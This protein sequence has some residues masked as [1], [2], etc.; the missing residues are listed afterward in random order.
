MFTFAWLT[1]LPGLD[2][3]DE[4]GTIEEQL[5]AALAPELAAVDHVQHTRRVSTYSGISGTT[6]KT[7]FSQEEIQDL[8]S[9]I[10]IDI[11]PSL[12]RSSEE[13]AKFLL[14][15]DLKARPVV[16]KE[17]RTVNSKYN[18][19]YD[20]RLASVNVHKHSFGSTQFIQPSIVLRALFDVQSAQDVPPGPWRPDGVIY[21]INL[22]QMLR[23]VLIVLIDNAEITTEGYNAIEALDVNFASAIAGPEFQHNAFELQLSLLTQLAIIRA[24]AYQ[25]DPTF[26]I[27][28]TITDTFFIQDND[29]DL[30][31]KH[32][33]VLHMMTLSPEQQSQYTDAIGHR[34]DRIIT[35]LEGTDL[36]TGL[37]ALRAQYLWEDFVETVIQY[38]EQ[39]KQEV[40]G[41]IAAV[42]GIEQIIAGLSEEVERRT[43]ARLA[44]EKRK[45]FTKP[46]PRKS[47]GK[48]GIK[49]LKARE[50][51]LAASTAPPAPVAE[52]A[53]VAQMTAPAA[54]LPDPAPLPMDDGWQRQDEDE[55]E[56]MLQ[57]LKDAAQ[58]TA[59]S[60]LAALTGFQD[61][62]HRN[63][64]KGKG[65]SF[66]DRQEGAQRVAWDEGQLTQEFNAGD[67]QYPA[68]SARPQGPYY[69]SPQ[70]GSVK[71]PY[72]L[73][74]EQR[75]QEDQEQEDFE[76][77]QDQGFEVDNRSLAAA[78]QR[79][80]ALPP[81]R[82]QPR[83]SSLASSVPIPSNRAS[84]SVE[85]SPS[86][87]QRK[88][89]GSSIPAIPAPFDPEDD[90]NEVPRDQR[91]E[92]ARNAARHNTVMASQAK[93]VQVRTGW[94]DDEDNAL[95]NLI[96]HECEEGISYAKLKNMDDAGAGRL[97]RRSAEDMR[98]KA[99]NMKETFLK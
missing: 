49:A 26:D 33:A 72:P 39:R 2:T 76:P 77:T 31:F 14:P 78:D 97:G 13:L 32:R 16:R 70:R 19:L 89:P 5:Q 21:N 4:N 36:V 88:N 94:T 85:P 55:D 28:N 9:D 57:P 11:L 62:Q 34:A 98:F 63:A 18:K 47:F 69:Q 64:G 60:T 1:S 90:R 82:P 65:K 84:A 54:T 86:K 8:D 56:Q 73:E 6:A 91:M 51:Q 50:K 59:R 35:M 10:M 79:R 27:R 7:S 45:S 17:I 48:S 75:P 46:A 53:P 22:A 68:S 67:F 40:N 87:R 66:I 52:V 74:N 96:E 99:R 29:G 80:R 92:R 37:G 12:F 71:R 93:P 25:T 81:Q 23:I 61:Q 43:S 42:G 24:T 58:S 95:I 30:V 41:E 3:V 44:Q 38:Y 15:A 83:F 20:T